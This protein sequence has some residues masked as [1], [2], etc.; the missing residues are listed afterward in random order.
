MAAIDHVT[1]TKNIR[2]AFKV[3]NIHVRVLKM[4]YLNAKDPLVYLSPI[5]NKLIAIAI[6]NGGRSPQAYQ[7]S[8]TSPRLIVRQR[9]SYVTHTYVE[10]IMRERR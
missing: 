6:S 4:V 8:N 10:H 1:R 2:N 3:K 9:S 7:H 5:L